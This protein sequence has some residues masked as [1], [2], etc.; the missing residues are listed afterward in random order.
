[1]PPPM[2]MLSTKLKKRNSMEEEN[3]RS[4]V[5][6]SLATS[7]SISFAGLIRA[8]HGETTNT[9]STEQWNVSTFDQW[10]NGGST[11]TLG[12]NIEYPTDFEMTLPTEVTINQWSAWSID[13]VTD[14]ETTVSG[15]ECDSRTPPESHMW[16]PVLMLPAPMYN[17]LDPGNPY[18]TF[19]KCGRVGCGAIQY[20]TL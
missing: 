11:D 7:V 4:F 9:S 15:L 2:S 3:R 17:Q 8:A 18:Y 20:M 12:L 10:S 14:P 6:K 1:M 5:K 16:G 19:K 13:P